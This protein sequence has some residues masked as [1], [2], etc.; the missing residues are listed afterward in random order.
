MGT[1]AFE[2][3]L[4]QISVECMR[5]AFVFTLLTFLVIRVIPIQDDNHVIENIFEK[6]CQSFLKG[7]TSTL[8]I[9]NKY[10]NNKKLNKSIRPELNQEEHS[11]YNKP[12]AVLILPSVS[13]QV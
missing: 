5:I 1:D 6:V 8:T 11:C 12:M 7:L 2:D 10:F 3:C 13:V 9:R 4:H